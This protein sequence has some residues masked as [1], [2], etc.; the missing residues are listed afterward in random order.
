[1]E[2]L[3]RI[4]HEETVLV[5]S[6]TAAI[7][8]SC[9]VR[10]SE[11]YLSYI[12]FRVLVLLFC[13]MLVV[14]GFQKIGVLGVLAQRMTA[15][16]KN[17][18]ALCTSLILLCFF[19]SMLITN[20]VALI[21]FVP[22]SILVLTVT[23]QTNRMIFVIV[24]Q[25]VAANLGSMLTPV[26]NPQNLYLFS[27]YHIHATDFFKITLPITIAGLV[28]LALF[29]L[30]GKSE[31]IEVQFHSKSVIRSKKQLLLYAILF[32]LCIVTVFYLVDY[33]VTLLTV[34]ITV[35]WADKH[36]FRK[37]DY[38]LLATFVCF[39]I[40]VG[41]IGNIQSVRTA[42]ASLIAGHE[43]FFSVLLSQIISNVPCAV[44]LSTFTS[45]G[46]AL[47]LGTNIGGLG[48]LIASLASLISFKFYVKTKD[49]KPLKYL[50]IFTGINVL[51]LV[52]L[53]A[54]SACV[55][56]TVK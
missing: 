45:H 13:L 29:S 50:G 9:F 24:M 54:F 14:A 32:A 34:C 28:L 38:G 49:A 17:T 10:P 26:G 44:L 1:M 47:V 48:T 43:L 30:L 6:A 12:N 22:F 5:I 53:L 51:I 35:F 36:L 8:S 56:P 20:D 16:M 42:L 15:G 37:A 23:A 4:L 25:T 11:N 18:K 19:S 41:N 21:T 2:K 46:K 31:N 40:F 39:F 7:L 52:L 33:R 3:K 55:F 27:F